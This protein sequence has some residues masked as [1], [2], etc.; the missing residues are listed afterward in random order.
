[1]FNDV[2]V[3]QPSNY[4]RLKQIDLDDHFEYSKVVLIKSVNNSA[5]PFLVMNN[6]FNSSIDL[7]FSRNPTDA[8]RI[9][10]MDVSGRTLQSWDKNNQG[11]SRMRI[12]TSGT[13][14]AGTYLLEVRANG[15][16]YVEKIIKQ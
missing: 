9:R 6:P 4:Y 8:V 12:N 2:D 15:Q 11:L 7:Q 10:L 16:V 5:K 13:L 14:Q 1:V 3:A